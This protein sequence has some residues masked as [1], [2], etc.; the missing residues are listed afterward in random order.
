MQPP[1]P[2]EPT[3]T[4]GTLTS[5]NR[6]TVAPRTNPFAEDEEPDAEAHDHGRIGYSRYGRLSSIALAVV[7][8]V[9]L[10]GVG[11]YNRD[12]GSPVDPNA[13]PTAGVKTDR[14]A[15]DFSLTLFDGG[16]FSLA[17]QRGKI[18]VMNFWASWC[19]PC[20]EEMPILEQVSA[21]SAPDVVFIG[22][23]AKNENDD[24]D[25]RAFAKDHGVTY[26]IGRDTQGGDQTRGKIEQDYKIPGYPATFI[27]DA[28]G[29][30]AYIKVG[31]F[32]SAEQ[33]EQA[34]ADAR[35]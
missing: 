5:Q 2:D 17:D 31:G 3:P 21:S 29:N 32:T 4:S 27:I 8:V 1:S 6:E 20:K 19:Q 30:I 34:I 7:I 16:T 26:A 24:A 22:V 14:P 9:G 10:I 11:L 12:K 23:G 13:A 18:V 35:S 28:N 15:P 25:A 33:L